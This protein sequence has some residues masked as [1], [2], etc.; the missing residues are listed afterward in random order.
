M[1]ILNFLKYNNIVPVT[2]A[3]V[4]LGAGGAY[5][6]TNPAAILSAQEQVVSI[7]NTYI[8]NKNLDAYTP[9]VVIVNVKEDDEYYY[10]AYQFITIDLKDAAWQDV[11]KEEVMRVSKADLGPYRDL[12]LYVTEQLKQKI[13]RELARLKETQEFERRQVTQKIVATAYSGLIGAFLDDT[14]ETI[15]GYKPVVEPPPPP[16]EPKPTPPPVPQPQPATR[17][18]S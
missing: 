4:L 3:F 16:P 13:D 17:S 9:Q 1:P 12:G 8:A 18:D 11:L 6:A 15:P 5:A 7:D 2:V 10:V 14:T